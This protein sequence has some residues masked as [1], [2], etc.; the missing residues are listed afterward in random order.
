MKNQA[1]VATAARNAHGNH[2]GGWERSESRRGVV[3]IKAAEL[4]SHGG[5]S[6]YARIQRAY[7][8]QS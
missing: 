2:H 5:V 6:R 1:A 8:R 3:E 4:L 7:L